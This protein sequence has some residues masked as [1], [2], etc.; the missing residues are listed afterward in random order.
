MT[1]RCVIHFKNF[2]TFSQILLVVMSLSSIWNISNSIENCVCTCGYQN[3]ADSMNKKVKNIK[4]LKTFFVS[5]ADNS[6]PL[7]GWKIPL[8]PGPGKVLIKT[9]S[10]RNYCIREQHYFCK[11]PYLYWP[12]SNWTSNAMA[13]FTW[14]S[15]MRKHHTIFYF[16]AFK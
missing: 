13:F 12:A 1:H 7:W 11:F 4:R 10:A 8:T 15:R 16:S 6:G 2:H 3:E 9:Y 14:L 5:L